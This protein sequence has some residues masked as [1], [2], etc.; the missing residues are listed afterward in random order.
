MSHRWCFTVTVEL[1]QRCA[2]GCCM[3]ARWAL[4]GVDEFEFDRGDAVLRIR[5]GLPSIM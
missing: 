4:L 2:L 1:T 3:S 5:L